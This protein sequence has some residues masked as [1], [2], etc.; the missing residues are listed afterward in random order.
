MATHPP[1]SDTVFGCLPANLSAELFGK[2]RPVGLAA[3]EVLFL[4]GD[5]GDGCYRIESGLL[6]ASVVSASGTERILGIFGPGSIFGELS[7]IDGEPRSASMIAIR[8]S[9]VVFVSRANFDALALANPEICRRIMVLLARR[10][11]DVDN[12]LLATSFLSLKGRT[13]RLL[14][15]LADAFGEHVGSGRIVVRQK[16]SQSDLAAMAGIAR[17]NVSRILNDWT[18]R[19]LISRIAGYYCIENRTTL[20]REVDG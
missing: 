18:R 14:L 1:G 12:S 8:E 3:N 13:A 6:K 9:K 2:G 19:A 7:I 17:E 20:E 5:P 10:L 4:A 11:R 15:G 16:V